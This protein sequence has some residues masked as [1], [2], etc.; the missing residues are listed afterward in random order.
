MSKYVIDSATL[1]SIGDAVR[2]K[3]GTTE[4]ILVSDIATR[5]KAIPQEGGG[6]GLEIPEEAFTIT[7][8]CNYRFSGGGWDWFVEQIGNQISTKDLLSTQYM[9]Q[10]SNLESIPFD[11]NGTTV[12]SMSAVGIFYGCE[13]LTSIPKLNFIAGNMQQIFY[14]CYKL[15]EIT[16]ESV[17]NIDWTAVDTQATTYGYTRNNTFS[18]CYNLRK[19]PMSFLAHGNPVSAYSYGIYPSLFENC[20][21][22]DELVELPIQHRN[23]SWTSNGFRG[24]FNNC[25]RLKDIIFETNED[26][27]PIVVNNWTKQTISL[28]T[29]IGYAPYYTTI[30]MNTNF[31]RDKEV[32]DDATYQAL[33]E[34][35][36]WWT[37]NPKYSRYN[38]DSAVRT[39]NS[40]PDLSVKGGNTII[41]K[42]TSG[43]NTDG[44]ACGDLTAEEIAVATAKG[45]TVTLYV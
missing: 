13:K 27:T 20:Y 6:G 12:G 39:I 18:Y 11:I 9:F 22:L 21:V 10:N 34:D 15:E 45:W 8:D 7:G 16:E 28:N 44:G 32:T 31:T 40:L 35:P 3:D 41:F 43:A 30:T 29:N 42:E 1:A 4:A 36:D 33:K 25:H 14:N 2:E 38:H 17:A 19:F 26:G 5:I 37:V 23:A 24:T